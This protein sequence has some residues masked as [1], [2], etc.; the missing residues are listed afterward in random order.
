[1]NDQAINLLNRIVFNQEDQTAFALAIKDAEIFLAEWRFKN[2]FTEDW[3]ILKSSD[4]DFWL[5]DDLNPV[6]YN[7]DT[8]FE[9]TY[10]KDKR[11]KL[12][13]I[14]RSKLPKVNERPQIYGEFMSF[15]DKFKFDR[16]K[17]WLP[18]IL[19]NKNII[20]EEIKIFM[21]YIKEN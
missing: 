7:W 12:L 16:E 1:M 13:V 6:D 15:D 2:K 5:K 10:L 3:I 14:S 21:K 20:L 18:I 11:T 9:Q 4:G 17:Y 8:E 19:N